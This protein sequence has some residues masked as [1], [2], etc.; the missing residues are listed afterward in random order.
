MILLGDFDSTSNTLDKNIQQKNRMGQLMEDI[1]NRQKFYITTELQLTFKDSN[2]TGKR[3]IHLN[4]VRGLK[5]VQVKAKEFQLIKI[6]HQAIEV[7]IHVTQNN[8][9]HQSKFKT[10]NENWDISSKNLKKANKCIN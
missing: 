4:F 8:V 5:N 9:K 1:I 3:I 2:N 6:G 10:K 7:L